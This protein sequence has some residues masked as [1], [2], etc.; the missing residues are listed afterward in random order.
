MKK[1]LAL[2]AALF[3]SS[4]SAAIS[5][6]PH[7]LTGRAGY[8]NTGLC[9][10]CHMPHN[11]NAAAPVGAP[12]W[13]KTIQPNSSYTFYP[14]TIAQTPQA[15][16]L[17]GVSAACLSCHDG[18]ANAVNTQW[19]GTSMTGG[20]NYTVN[21]GNS[22]GTNIGKNLQNDHPVSITYS[23]NTTVLTTAGLVS[24]AQA[25]SNGMMF[26]GAS[27]DQLECGSC[28]DPHNEPFAN[29]KF[30]RIASGQDICARCHNK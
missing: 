1:M 25:T 19:N 17:G 24:L 21:G 18:T 5:G 23:S 7:D 27:K 15:T 4:A 28:H 30:L 11:S 6:T 29:G 9:T 26:F 12:L 8:N 10:F 20:T 22:G 13:S 16:A 3:A 2:V 14:A